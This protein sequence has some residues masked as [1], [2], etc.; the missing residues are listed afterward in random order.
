MNDALVP[1][2][3]G[4]STATLCA[5]LVPASRSVARPLGILDAPAAS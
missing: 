3:V 5:A 4:V 2:E 1:L